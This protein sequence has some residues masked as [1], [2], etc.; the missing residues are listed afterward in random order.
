MADRNTRNYPPKLY[1]K[2]ENLDEDCLLREETSGVDRPHPYGKD[3]TGKCVWHKHTKSDIPFITKE[4][5]NTWLRRS[6]N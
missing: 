1:A 6:Q 5:W 2:G 3:A 4:G